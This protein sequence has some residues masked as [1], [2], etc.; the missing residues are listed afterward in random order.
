MNPVDRVA[1]FLQ[2]AGIDRPAEKTIKTEGGTI[3]KLDPL[4]PAERAAAY[5]AAAARAFALVQSAEEARDLTISHAKLAIT[6]AVAIGEF[7]I[8][9]AEVFSGDFDEWLEGY[10]AE[11]ISRPTA[12]RYMKAVRYQHALGDD[13]PEFS[14]LKDLFI[15]AGILPAPTSGEGEGQKPS[16]P[17][18][19]L[20]FEINASGNPGEWEPVVRREFI[21]KAKPIAELLEKAIAAE[22][23]A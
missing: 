13:C 23:E 19:R 6:R 11:R 7:L 21:A 12:Y 22:E 17:I 4:T 15:A 9:M 16:P 1:K 18:F 10:C 20:R 8:E 14:T 3:T 5:T 2:V